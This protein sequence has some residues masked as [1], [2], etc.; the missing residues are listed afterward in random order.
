[1]VNPRP[2][3][4]PTYPSPSIIPYGG[5]HTAADYYDRY[6]GTEP[7]GLPD[8]VPAPTPEF[9]HIIDDPKDFDN[10]NPD[11]IIKGLNK[12]GVH[13]E[14]SDI[15]YTVTVKQKVGKG[16]KEKVEKA[17]L[18][19]VHGTAKPGEILAI[20]GGSGAGKTTLL[21]ALAG[22]L[23]GKVQGTLR[24]N[25][26][27]LPPG[28]SGGFSKAYVFQGD[29]LYAV[30]TVRE[31][32][33][34]A[35]RFQLPA[36]TTSEQRKAVVERWLRILGM[37]EVENVKVGDE[38]V[39]GLSGGQRRRLSIGIDLLKEPKLIFL[40]EPISG[41]D[42]TS[43]FKVVKAIQELTVEDTRTV[44]MTIHQPSPR[45]LHLL[46]TILV[47]AS[48]RVV[49][50]GREDEIHGYL[51]DVAKR[52]VPGHVGPVEF[53]LDVID[54]LR[55]EG[56]SVDPLAD[57]HDTRMLSRPPE[58]VVDV[59][60][61]PKPR[62][63]HV[64]DYVTLCRRTFLIMLRTPEL[65]I[66]RFMFCVMSGFLFSTIFWNLGTTFQDATSRI[67]YFLMGTATLTFTSVEVMP[68]FAAERIIIRREYFQ[69]AYSIIN[70]ILAQSTIW[71]L[72]MIP[73]SL[74][75]T[76]CSYWCVGLGTTNDYAGTF[77]FTWL[78]WFCIM[79]AANAFAMMMSAVILSPM[80]SSSA[81][82]AIFA[83]M[84]VLAG[85]FVPRS[86]IPPYWI[87]FHYISQFKYA[88]FGLAT[89]YY[90]NMPTTQFGCPPP[91]TND[92]SCT[93]TGQ[94]IL[95]YY[96]MNG[97]NQWASVGALIGL[98]LLWRI[99]HCV[100]L[101]LRFYKLRIRT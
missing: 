15:C 19:G 14:W 52:S 8:P 69:Q 67:G 86:D 36:N 38:D 79:F 1:M 18:S 56:Q 60:A 4:Y 16:K 64:K 65:F 25:G 7:S 35:A 41:L 75:W 93:L 48:G 58:E 80:T 66:G 57:Y 96:D 62:K 73:N 9:D 61:P 63:S 23:K 31:T 77:L 24:I 78:M 13:M 22:R 47:M 53:F 54:E 89:N 72:T 50:Q 10:Y 97:W 76:L 32:L 84:L 55:E 17:L 30:L 42:S 3:E 6:V 83:F 98:G 70:Y 12:A 37:K 91:N 87:W 45:I 68:M 2:T 92:P 85:F 99:I 82:T 33:L 81:S 39:K 101:Y 29:N 28:S 21:D 59:V 46:N 27:G 26:Q 94:Q 20:M 100:L 88:I 40:D 74:A 51:R 95:E 5:N 49:F 90:D 34:F 44:L 71:T 43:A 11:A